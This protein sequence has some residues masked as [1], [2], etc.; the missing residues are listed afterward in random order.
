MSTYL[1]AFM[2]TDLVNTNAS[3]GL[4]PPTDLPEINIWTRKDVADM[5]RCASWIIAV[6]KV[7]SISNRFYCIAVFPSWTSRYAY[8]LATKLLPF[9]ERYFGIGFKLPKIDMVAVPDFGFSAMENWGETEGHRTYFKL[10]DWF[11]KLLW[12]AIAVKNVCDQ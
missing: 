2:V 9:Y 10:H 7:D 12:P 8:T 6:P 11:L 4:S 3:R 1:V 5:T